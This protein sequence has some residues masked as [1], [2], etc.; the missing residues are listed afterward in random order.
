[1]RC[2]GVV[3]AAFV[4]SC[5]GPGPA[6]EFRPAYGFEILAA[7]PVA[8][9]GRRPEGLPQG[10]AGTGS[11]VL[12]SLILPSG[13]RIG[14][15]AE[16]LILQLD[17]GRCGGGPL[18]PDRDVP[19]LATPFRTP[20]A[21]AILIPDDR[22]GGDVRGDLITLHPAEGRLLRHMFDRE[23][24]GFRVESE[25]L[26]AWSGGDLRHMESTSAGLVLS[27][28]A[29]AFLLRRKS[30][31]PSTS[32]L[33]ALPK[34]PQG[35]RHA[36]SDRDPEVRGTAAVLL[37]P[38]KDSEAVPVLVR[39][40]RSDI[41]WVVREAALTLAD[42]QVPEAVESLAL[43][44]REGVDP[45]LEAALTRALE[46]CGSVPELRDL[47]RDP[48]PLLRKA[49]LL[50]LER[51]RPGLLPVAELLAH[52]DPAQAA[53]ERAARRIIDVRHA[54]SEAVR[55]A[56]AEDPASPRGEGIWVSLGELPEASEA[57]LGGLKSQPRAHL[58]ILSRIDP[59]SWPEAWRDVLQ[60]LL[61]HDDDEVVR[62]ALYAVGADP[63]PWQRL[64]RAVAGDSRR[65]LEVRVEALALAEGAAA[66]DAAFFE[67]MIQVLNRES[68]AFI[69]LTT[70]R[71]LGRAALTA[72]QTN[73]L[74][75][76]FPALSP[77]ELGF[78]LEAYEG[79]GPG[80]LLI[81]RLSKAPATG[82]LRS[83]V[84]QRVLKRYPEPVRRRA[85]D[86][87]V[88]A[89]EEADRRSGRLQELSALVLDGGDPARG[90]EVLFGPRAECT[91]CHTVRGQGARV[92]PELTRIGASKTRAELLEAIAF[93]S[94]SFAR[95]YETFRVRTRDG[96]VIDG[97]LARESPEAV[98]LV[99]GD[100]SERRVPRDAV[101]RIEQGSVSIMPQG[102]AER[103]S[104][105]DLRD[106]LAYL[107][108][109]R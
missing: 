52:L 26:L 48:N 40:I 12:H 67:S 99:Q 22:L 105:D 59:A 1:M 31:K 85:R 78:V 10:C 87:G 79:G 108:S 53:A 81:D 98:V 103:L 100:R 74:L 46:T 56:A 58:G 69:R 86:L 68:R 88:R 91:A 63:G 27:G 44:L 107:S 8:P 90:R 47:L 2:F 71:A 16:A 32:T 84:L 70:A 28:P 96:D 43:R 7:A 89:D 104:P 97:F 6:R 83:E 42:L 14:A 24:A 3:V 60:G 62:R 73:T 109:L 45:F 29:E 5:S 72:A 80:S 66:V 55:A 64:L 95:G 38:L 41:P 51:K 49:A 30:P 9:E 21:Q 19:P 82:G 20:P 37:R 36:L 15:T 101:E 34:D 65:A 50:G 39:M 17:L 61:D 25:D 18:C 57:I 4:G 13:E 54:R 23:G 77:L 106:L 94:A 33:P 92:G 76:T 35:L 75:E 11:P 93:P 102:F